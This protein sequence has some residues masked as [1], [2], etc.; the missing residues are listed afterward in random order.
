GDATD[1][2]LVERDV[3]ELCHKYGVRELAYD[4]RFA[5]SLRLH[6]EGGGI[7]CIDVPQGYQL[8]EAI[9]KIETLVAAGKL[10]PGDDPILAWMISNVA[11]RHGTRQEVRLDKERASEKID[12][13]AALAMAMSRAILQPDDSPLQLWITGAD[14]NGAAEERAERSGPTPV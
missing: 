3:A 2:D 10:V 14:E 7:I 4:R 13:V 11:L 9:R 1:L 6:W 12:G 8:T 5:E